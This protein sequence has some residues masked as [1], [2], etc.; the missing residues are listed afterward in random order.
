MS[1]CHV[2]NISIVDASESILLCVGG[3]RHARAEMRTRCARKYMHVFVRVCVRVSVCACV[4]MCACMHE[5]VC[6]SLVLVGQPI[7]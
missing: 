6:Q 5:F 1:W 3:S 4:R 7:T 2:R